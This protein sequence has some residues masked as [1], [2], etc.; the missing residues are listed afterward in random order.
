MTDFI[1]PFPSLP[2]VIDIGGDRYFMG[3]EKPIELSFRS[4]QDYINSF[5]SDRQTEYLLRK[6]MFYSLKAKKRLS[7]D[8]PED[9]EQLIAILKKR[10]KNITASKQFTSSVLKNTLLQRSFIN[11]ERLVQELEGAEYKKDGEP[12][13]FPDILPCTKAKKYVKQIPEDKLFQ[14][15]IEIAWYLVHPDQVPSKIQCDWAKLVKELDMLRLDNIVSEIRQAEQA[16]GV[17]PSAQAF[18]YFKKIN[19]ETLAKSAK[20]VNNALEQAKEMALQIQAENASN[21][22]KERLKALM[23][24][25]VLKK[26]LSNDLQQIDPATIDKIKL[27]MPANPMTGGNKTIGGAVKALEKP[28]G[29]AIQPLFDYF[30]VVFDPIYSLVESSLTTYSKNSDVV[31]KVV[32]PQLTTLLHICNNLNPSETAEGGA[33]TYGIYRLKNVDPE[34]ITFLNTMLGSTSTY[35]SQFQDDKDKNTFNRQL[36]ELPKVRLTSLLNKFVNSTTYKDPDTI[37]YIQFLSV[38]GNVELQSKDKFMDPKNPQ[39]TEQVF[40]AINEYFTKDNLYI[41]CTK[42]ENTSQDIPMNMYEID[43]DTV[44]VADVGITIDNIPEN[45]FN[46]NKEPELYLENLVTLLPYVVFNDAELALS[47]FIAFKELMPK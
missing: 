25:L 38:G 3:S 26:Y 11:I 16:K 9:K 46:K 41:L 18:N 8:S 23:D 37:P 27:D 4:R 34:I 45:Y 24:V 1:D 39:H 5:G 10:A 17:E 21:D 13:K 42:S 7:F 43:F 15:I 19:L 20:S 31:K 12:F 32:I 2:Q 29:V 47:I 35:L 40:N 36:F 33:N 6:Y 28:L 44:D 22:I 14:M 30:K